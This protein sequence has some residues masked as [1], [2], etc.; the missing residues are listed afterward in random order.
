MPTLDQ[1][2]NL[3]V[4]VGRFLQS[5]YIIPGFSMWTAMQ[6][7]IWFDLAMNLLW[8]FLNQGRGE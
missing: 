5:W 3:T 1:L 4:F 8:F 6:I 2:E 7:F